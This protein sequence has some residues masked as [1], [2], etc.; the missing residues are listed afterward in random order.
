MVLDLKELKCPI[1]LSWFL[2]GLLFWGLLVSFEF[3]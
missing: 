1:S 3:V 2:E